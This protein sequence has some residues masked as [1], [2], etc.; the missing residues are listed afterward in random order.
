MVNNNSAFLRYLASL[1]S[2]RHVC[3][4]VGVTDLT[5]AVSLL[6]KV[7]HGGACGRAALVSGG[8]RHRSTLHR[9]EAVRSVG[10]ALPRLILT[11]Y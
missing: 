2:S 10:G 3:S 5:G 6:L 9:S 11:R 7:H 8:Q 4:I 1:S